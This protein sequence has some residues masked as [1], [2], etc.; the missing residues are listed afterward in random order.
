MVR[1]HLQIGMEVLAA[2]ERW[3]MADVRLPNAHAGERLPDSVCYHFGRERLALYAHGHGLLRRWE[4]QLAP[5]EA[6][7]EAEALAWIGAWADPGGMALLRLA[8]YEHRSMVARR[9]RQGN[10]LLAGDAAHLMPPSAGQG[11]CAGVRDAANLAWKLAAVARGQ[12]P[13]ALLDTYE[14]ERRPHLMGMM[15]RSHFIGRSVQGATAWQRLRRRLLFGALRRLPALQKMLCQQQRRPLPLGKSALG[16]LP[17]AGRPLP[18]A[19]RSDDALG[20]RWALLA[21]PEWPAPLL[22]QE[23]FRKGIKPLG[24]SE[25]LMG[26]MRREGLQWALVRPDKT[27]FAAGNSEADC[28]RAL[29]EMAQG[30][31]GFPASA[32]QEAASLTANI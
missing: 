31:W 18:Q 12:A 21:L 19:N 14:A 16:H 2:P 32:R 15:A 26:W 30:P 27:L 6:P 24:Q 1:T 22:R 17:W 29:G 25:F 11:L 10:V 4:F 28:L 3:A 20:Y 13:E 5:G 7:S 23:A 8:C 9:W